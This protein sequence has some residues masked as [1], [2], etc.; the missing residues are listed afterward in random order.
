MKG[1]LKTKNRRKILIAYASHFGTTADV[2]RT[3]GHI[4]RA[5]G[6]IVETKCIQDIKE[7]SC[8]DAV[9]VGSAIQY[10]KWMP[11][12]TAFV[13]DNQADL[14]K[15]PTAFFFTCLALSV[16]SEKSNHQGQV[17]ADRLAA[18]FPRIKP[19]SIGQF[20]GVLD[21]KKIPFIARLAARIAFAFLGV[22][23][24]DHRDWSA[25]KAW[26]ES[27]QPDLSLS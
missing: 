3:I 10:D 22:K 19:V 7:V 4:L 2:A 26:T 1:Q 25:I 15:I 27:I 20:A 6:S 16:R 17:Y 23:E 14:A 24:G 21:Y 18:P 8:Y 13:R 9:I 12:A 11:D 5:H